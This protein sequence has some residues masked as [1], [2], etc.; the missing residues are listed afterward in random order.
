MN[1]SL[2]MEGRALTLS[3]TRRAVALPELKMIA[4]LPVSAVARR[5]AW[6]EVRFQ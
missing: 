6:A 4:P 5:L 2:N 3:H 1:F